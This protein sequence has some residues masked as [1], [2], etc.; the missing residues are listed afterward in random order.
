MNHSPLQPLGKR[1][2]ATIFA[3]KLF[4]ALKRVD[5]AGTDYGRRKAIQNPSQPQLP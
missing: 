5:L 1:Y 3:E 4:T 2:S